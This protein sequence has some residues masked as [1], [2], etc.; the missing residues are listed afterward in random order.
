MTSMQQKEKKKEWTDLSKTEK[1]KIQAS[2]PGSPCTH[3]GRKKRSD[4]GQRK[5]AASSSTETNENAPRT[6]KWRNAK[7]TDAEVLREV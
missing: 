4:K 3:C 6:N 7:K 1:Q 5:A 2:I